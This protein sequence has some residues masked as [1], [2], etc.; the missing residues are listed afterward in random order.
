MFR[1]PQPGDWAAEDEDAAPLPT[2]AP[3]SRSPTPAPAPAASAPARARGGRFER[4]R[5]GRFERE[6]DAGGRFE[7]DSGA[8][9]RDYGGGRFDR[10]GGRYDRDYDRGGR[11][12]GGGGRL[13]GGGRYDRDGGRFDR[14]GGRAEGGGRADAGRWGHYADRRGDSGRGGRDLPVEQGFVVAIKESFGFVSCLEREGDLFFHISEAPVDV[15]LQDEVE[16]RV[17]YNQRSDK[18]MACQLVALPKG[19]I[20]VEEVSD[21]FFDGVVTKSLPRGGHGGGRGF[22]NNR[23]DDRHQREEHGLIEVKKP[24]QDDDVEAEA[25]Q[26]NDSAKDAAPEEQEQSGESDTSPK[27]PLV[28]REFVRFTS[29]SVAV[30]EEKAEGDEQDQT[31]RPRKNP[32]PH[33]GD[34]VHFRIAKHRKTGVKRAVDITITVSA[35]EKLEKEIEAKLATMTRETGVVDRVKNG[36][37]FIKCCDRPVDVYFPIHEIREPA[38]PEEDE[39]SDNKDG[40]QTEASDKPRRVRQGKGSTIRE[41]DEVSF[42]VYEDQDDDSARSRSRLTAL[43]VQKLPPGTVSF[44]ELIRADVEGVV[45]KLPKEPRNAPEVIGSITL[46]S[47]EQDVVEKP[48]EASETADEGEGKPLKKKKG[49]VSKTKK[50]KVSFRL[51]DTE[52][53]SYVPHMDDKVVFDEVLDKRTGKRKAVKVRVVQLNPKNRE[54]G[55]INAMKE[56]FGFIKCAERASDAYFRF[57]DVMGTSRNFSNGTEVAFDVLADTKS[58]HIRATRLQILPRGTI[59]WDDVAAEDLEGTIIALPSSR[60]GHISN[61]GGRGDNKLKQLQK[62]VH[63]KVRFVTPQKQHLVDFLPELKEKIDDAFVLSEDVAE[64]P[65]KDTAESSTS[66][67][68]DQAESKA[69][70]RISFPSSLSKF[71][72][73]AL[74]EYSDWLGLKHESSGEGSHR[75]LEIVGSEKI[76]I[77]TIEEKLSASAPELTLEFKEDDVDDVRYNPHVGDRVKF[78]LVVVKRTKQFQCKSISLVEA[79]S[80]ASTKAKPASAKND[81]AKGEGFIVAVKPEGFGFIQPAQTIPGSM[82]ENLF[83]HIK[84]VTTGQTLADLK[85]GTEV[86]YTIFV[87]EKRKKKRAIGISIVPAGTIKTVV[88]ESVKGVVTKASF[89]SRMKSGP[90]GRFTNGNNKMSTLGRIRLA[91]AVAD[92]EDDDADSD[93]DAESDDEVEETEEA[94]QDKTQTDEKDAAKK[95]E[96]KKKESTQKKPGKQVYLF[97]IRDIADPAAVLREGDEVEFIPQV[98]PKNLRAANIRL[99]A[100]HAKKG[101][102]TRVNEDLG[103]VIRLD[104]DESEPVVEASYTARS[105]LRGDILSEGDRVEFAYRMPSATPSLRN[106][107]KKNVTDDKASEEEEKAN[108][109]EENVPEEPILGQA[110]SV[111]RIS[112]S[113]N[114]SEASSNRRGS[115]SVNSTLKEAMRQV[116]AN[117]MVASRMAKGPDGTRG[118]AEGWNSPSEETTEDASQTTTVTSESETT[119]T[120]STTT[121]TTSVKTVT[122]TTE[123][124]KEA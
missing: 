93:A 121:T 25:S 85:E 62:Y 109:S 43:R 74:H 77:K 54:T 31:S 30:S 14:D 105:V 97:N 5:G 79:A 65:Q 102:V 50:Q 6:R 12:D 116:G 59:K 17:K 27:K 46:P 40:E 61:R 114:S 15:Q 47:T 108:G 72:R 94:A 26:G 35:R 70:I 16:F 118:F 36:G 53:M 33:F 86:Q 91:T 10:G 49:N 124:Q 119:K 78:D 106:A 7:R 8:R 44:E 69:E 104:G 82:E 37:G 2:P 98:T 68:E 89:L 75:H 96:K 87:D 18:E 39:K 51:C 99:I 83:F 23:D 29:D 71:E 73:A 122:S 90:K 123:E 42:Y 100:S 24:M 113:P 9:D 1:S 41:G 19:T 76:S 22:F 20:K 32:I 101:T 57:S 92:T 48:D 38:Q 66:A 115:R 52:D 11:F 112:S 4:E 3:A 103:G 64:E 117:A 45:S 60:R 21:E 55:V 95:T 58:D 120:T 81:A 88:P 13:D 107:L 111:L 34:E 63:G 80:N 28:R 110:V 84:E 67:S 56:D